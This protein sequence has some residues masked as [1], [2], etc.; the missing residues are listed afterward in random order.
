MSSDELRLFFVVCFAFGVYY[1]VL[2]ASVFAGRFVECGVDTAGSSWR[3]EFGTDCGEKRAYNFVIDSSQFGALCLA[4]LARAG[5]YVNKNLRRDALACFAC[6]ILLSWL[7]VY[8][9]TSSTWYAFAAIRAAIVTVPG[10]VLPAL[11]MRLLHAVKPSER[12]KWNN[13]LTFG[14]NAVYLAYSP[15][16][17]LSTGV[18]APYLKQREWRTLFGSS[19]ILLSFAC[20]VVWLNVD[21]ARRPGAISGHGEE[22][23]VSSDDR[24]LGAQKQAEIS[25]GKQLRTRAW[26]FAVPY[27]IALPQSHVGIQAAS[28]MKGNRHVSFLVVQ[29]AVTLSKLLLVIPSRFAT[30]MLPIQSA[31]TVSFAFVCAC[32][33]S[34]KWN[35]PWA[36]S[37]WFEW[38][39]LAFVACAYVLNGLVI[40]MY[41]HK[42]YTI[43][44]TTE[45]NVAVMSAS[46]ATSFAAAL[47][48]LVQALAEKD[49]FAS[50]IV[51]LSHAC[52]ALVLNV[53]R[54]WPL[55]EK[56]V[57]VGTPASDSG[58]RRKYRTVTL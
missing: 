3:S 32:E 36:S 11:K 44:E 41:F 19:L 21:D 42:T 27:F 9:R 33:A 18:M 52:V 56:G 5:G 6:L 58:A 14:V 46:A 50:A 10:T 48:P 39:V 30:D 40:N 17:M 55:S 37:D 20:G 25:L 57:A 51:A 26:Y 22:R 29:G 35:S 2:Y 28:Y 49:Q 24:A 4:Q 15:L 8:R 34:L 38:V 16:A 13:W 7:A 53:D 1:L 43:L 47:A 12:D 45:R 54:A 31:A 23:S